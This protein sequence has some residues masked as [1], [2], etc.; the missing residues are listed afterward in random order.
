MKIKVTRISR[1]IITTMLESP[2][3]NVLNIRLIPY[4]PKHAAKVRK[5]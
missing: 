3:R 5:A 4:E 2:K 1:D